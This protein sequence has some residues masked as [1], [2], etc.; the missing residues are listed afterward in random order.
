MAKKVIKTKIVKPVKNPEIK[1]DPTLLRWLPVTDFNLIPRH[2]VES[3]L[4]D[5]PINLELLYNSATEI[6]DGY[7]NILQVMVDGQSKIQGFIWLYNNPLWQTIHVAMCAISEDYR[8]T[9]KMSKFVVD[10]LLEWNEKLMFKI[11]FN[12]AHPKVYKNV[13]EVKRSK[14]ILMEVSP[15]GNKK[16]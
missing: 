9:G 11:T 10:K 7:H 8:G 13:K 2:L 14:H 1:Y 3:C 4:E 6:F 16:V 5:V 12:T 15:A